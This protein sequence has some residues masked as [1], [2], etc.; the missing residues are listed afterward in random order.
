[1][2]SLRPLSINDPSATRASISLVEKPAWR[3]IYSPCS[4]RRGGYRRTGRRRLVATARLRSLLRRSTLFNS[5]DSEGN[6]WDSKSPVPQGLRNGASTGGAQTVGLRSVT[7]AEFGSGVC[8]LTDTP[9]AFVIGNITERA[10]TPAGFL[11]TRLG[12]EFSGLSRPRVDC[13]AQGAFHIVFVLLRQHPCAAGFF[14]VRKLR[15][16]MGARGRQLLVRFRPAVC[17][18][19]LCFMCHVSQPAIPA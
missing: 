2:A 6:S 14:L 10:A 13:Q 11:S 19:V 4:L 3:K 15:L 8:S 1:M 18:A 12:S 16:G 5:W 7:V 9:H 17:F